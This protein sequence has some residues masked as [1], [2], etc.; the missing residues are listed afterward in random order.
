[1]NPSTVIPELKRL[2]HV[3]LSDNKISD[4]GSLRVILSD[5]KDK[6]PK[7]KTLKLTKNPVA[8]MPDFQDTVQEIFTSF[9]YDIKKDLFVY[10]ESMSE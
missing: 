1:M 5:I 2:K 3:N 9:R 8:V 10:D 7:L 6:F 4:L